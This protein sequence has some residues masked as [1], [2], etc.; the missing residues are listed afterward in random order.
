MFIFPFGHFSS[1]RFYTTH[2]RGS[3][4][5]KIREGGLTITTVFFSVAFQCILIT[6]RVI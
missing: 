4:S 5:A 1:K 3:H 6:V 2:M